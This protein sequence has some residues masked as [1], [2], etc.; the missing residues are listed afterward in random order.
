MNDEANQLLR[1]NLSQ[2]TKQTELL[3]KYL[4]PLWTKIRFSLLTLLLLMT[5]VAIGLGVLVYEGKRPA[6]SPPAPLPIYRIVPP[7]PSQLRPP[8]AVLPESTPRRTF[9]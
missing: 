9:G 5:G 3:Q 2:Q 8:P 7:T 1:E 6:S 4:P